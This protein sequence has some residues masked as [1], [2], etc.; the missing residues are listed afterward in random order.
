MQ[1]LGEYRKAALVAARI[2]ASKMG[3]YTTPSGSEYVGDA[4]DEQGNLIQ[5]VEAGVFE[6][7]PSGYDFKTFDADYPHQQFESFIKSSMRDIAA[8]LLVSY[9][10]FSDD[11]ETVNFSSLRGSV[12]EAR[13]TWKLLQNFF[14][15][16]ALR[17]LFEK[18]LIQEIASGELKVR[19]KPLL[20]SNFDRYNK[21]KFIPRRWQWVDPLKDANASKVEVEAGF[22]SLSEI[23]REKGREPEEVFAEM[24]RERELMKKYGVTLGE[25][26]SKVEE[27]TDED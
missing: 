3:F 13:E 15:D 20:M 9:N 23:I 17:P 8:G 14:T 16:E 19:G 22:R 24:Q 4:E 6:E 7:L 1:H 11:M 21:A 10:D 27:D 12:I 5:E 25:V 26:V 2:G 18:W